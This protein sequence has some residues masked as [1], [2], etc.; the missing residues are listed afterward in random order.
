MSTIYLVDQAAELKEEIS[1]KTERLRN[2]NVEIAGQAEFAEGS[3][4]GHAFGCHYS[5]KVALK[6]NVKWDQVK[7]EALRAKIGDEDF[8]KIF[9]WTFEPKSAKT[10]A[11]AVEFGGH[12]REIEAARTVTAGTPYVT[13]ERLESC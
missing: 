6:E 3:K 11:G 5:A 12:S 13:Y 10:L 1:V 8:F 9:K 7:L 4:T 2:L